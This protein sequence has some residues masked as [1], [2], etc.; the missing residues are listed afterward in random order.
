MQIFVTN[1]NPKKSAD[2]LWTNPNRA[3]KMITESMQILACALE[4]FGYQEQIKKAN[5]D[6]YATPKSRMN[7]PVVKWV[8][9]D[10][11]HVLWLCIHCT[12]LYLEYSKKGGRAFKN[13]P[14][15]IDIIHNNFKGRLFEIIEGKNINFLN[16]AKCK[17]KDLDFT[18]LPVF[19]AYRQYLEAQK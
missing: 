7:H 15:N 16:F 2:Y 6:P 4:Y 10:K 19:E 1:P 3:R 13:I 8:C 11:N 12:Q 9:E 14:N 5:G 17:S 18:N